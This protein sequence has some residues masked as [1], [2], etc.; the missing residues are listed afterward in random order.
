M[1]AFSLP[2]IFA[3]SA[4]MHISVQPYATKIQIPLLI[5]IVM[6]FVMNCVLY[7]ILSYMLSLQKR[8]FESQMAMEKQ[9]SAE[10]HYQEAQ[11]L[12]NEVRKYNHDFNRHI[13][14]LTAF[15]LEKDYEK[16]LDYLNKIH[17]YS[18]S[19]RSNFKF[20]N[21]ELDCL[22]NMKL[23]ALE[24]VN[25]V[26]KGAAAV[27]LN[28]I[29]DVDLVCLFGNILDNA[30]EAVQKADEK[31][32]ELLFN[33]Y[34]SSQIIICRNTIQGSVMEHN[35]NLQTTKP[36]DGHAHGYG[37]MI[38][39]QI[40][41]KYGGYLDYFEEDNMFVVQIHFLLPEESE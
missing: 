14:L 33:I 11:R 22:I 34:N 7:F 23:S 16:A 29:Q 4:M 15:L 27:N 13:E 1:L 17:P 19:V 36:N 2:M 25:V 40:V 30:I 24:D 41:E 26:C 35:R 3:L 37:N 8:Q 18:S 31:R 32:I 20:G 21:Q 9:R 5:V 39:A 10:I 12:W 6:F 38:V 28:F